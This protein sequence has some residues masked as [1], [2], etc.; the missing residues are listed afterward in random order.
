[1][2][3]LLL[4]IIIIV[5]YLWI[6][7]RRNPWVKFIKHRSAHPLRGSSDLVDKIKVKSIVRDM[8][9]PGLRILKTYAVIDDPE[10]INEELLHQLP[11][12]YI[13]KLNNGSSRNYISN[14]TTTPEELQKKARKWMTYSGG[15]MYSEMQYAGVKNKIMFEELLPEENP[16][17]YKY[18]VIN[19]EPVMCQ[20]IKDRFTNM[21]SEFQP[22]DNS[23]MTQIARQLGQ[24]FKFDYVRIDLYNING[25]IYFGEYTFTPDA[26]TQMYSP[27][28]FNKHIVECIRNPS[29]KLI[30]PPN[31]KHQR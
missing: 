11:K 23:E 18:H 3:L 22:V 28:W 29:M 5:I 7:K 9:I 16:P 13:M 12:K 8:D 2:Y 14:D 15:G 24:R 31:L 1:M 6:K 26:G 19:G 20:V 25:N 17:D 10:Q 30:I 27:R 21:K 4:F